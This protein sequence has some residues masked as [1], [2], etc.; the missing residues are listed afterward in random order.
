MA[1]NDLGRVFKRLGLSKHAYPVYET[2]RKH[3]PLLA[4]DI[5]RR[6]R[7]HRPAAYK[8]L[9]E[10]SDNGL[11]AK[12]KHG[13]RSLW[14]ATNPERI[15]DLFVS[16]VGRIKGLIPKERA[17]SANDLSR[18]TLKILKGRS[19]VRAVFDDAIAHTKKG[20]TFFRYTSETDL[21]AVNAYLS[22]DY[23]K[24]RD[25]KR[26]ERR[27]ISNPLSGEQKRPRL[28]RFIKFIKPETDVFDQNII[29][30]IYENRVAF[31]DLNAEEVMI[32]ENAALA[33]F[34]KVIFKQLYKRL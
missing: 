32:I 17:L 19:G 12:A 23:R 4:T 34:Q 2:V 30:L 8:A 7:V 20:G 9:F 26:L 22:S 1:K 27:V 15:V 28:E 14:R 24:K 21:A 16:E 18:S 6:S 10:L 3:G 33:D 5:V 13:K 25:A 29:E 11:V 31:I